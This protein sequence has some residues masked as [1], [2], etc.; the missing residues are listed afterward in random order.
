MTMKLWV[1]VIFDITFLA[2]DGLASTVFFKI[3]LS[4]AIFSWEN[5]QNLSFW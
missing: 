1:V 4:D 5:F 3:A 2:L